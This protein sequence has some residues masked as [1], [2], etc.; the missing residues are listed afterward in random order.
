MIKNMS[1]EIFEKQ[2]SGCVSDQYAQPY[3]FA[4]YYNKI[5]PK[6]FISTRKLN[7]VSDWGFSTVKSFGNYTFPKICPT[8]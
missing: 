7:P 6:D 5:D 2:K 3:I 4:L 1:K 8:K